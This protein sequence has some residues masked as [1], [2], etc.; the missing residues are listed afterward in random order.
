MHDRLLCICRINPPYSMPV[1]VISF[2]PKSDRLACNKVMRSSN[3]PLLRLPPIPFA[4]NF[5]CQR[6]D[7]EYRQRE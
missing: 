7:V 6:G 5:P 2:P 4:M 1:G 3:L